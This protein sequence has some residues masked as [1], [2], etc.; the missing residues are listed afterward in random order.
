MK[1]IYFHAIGAIA[2]S[3][4]VAACV[5]RVAP[6]IALPAPA[7]RPAPSPAPTSSP[8]LQQP[9]YDNWMD[10]PQTP[11]NWE[12]QVNASGQAAIY[13][14]TNRNDQFVMTC[15]RQ[16]RQIG[17]LRSGTAAS[18]R[19]MRIHTETTT[20]QMQVVQAEDTNPYLTTDIAANDPLLDAMALSKGR[21]A[22]EVEGLPTLYLPSWAE[23]TRVIE[24]CR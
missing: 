9:A 20:R 8:V 18:P 14:A 17:L 3:F 11:G 19:I 24:D 16:R 22:V 23:V 6:P 7:Q 13:I 2:L 4:A 15:D 21:F 1:A 5:P 10:A 12:Y